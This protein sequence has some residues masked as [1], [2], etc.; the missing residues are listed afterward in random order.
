VTVYLFS[1]ERYLGKLV[2]QWLQLDS[3]ALV[4]LPYKMA[5][6]ALALMVLI[7]LTVFRKVPRLQEPLDGS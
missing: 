3:A 4:R 1:P 5:I 7:G 2:G 6:A